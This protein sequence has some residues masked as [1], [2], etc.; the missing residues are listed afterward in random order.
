MLKGRGLQESST[1]NDKP[2]RFVQRHPP[3]RAPLSH[4]RDILKLQT[5]ARPHERPCCLEPVRTVCRCL[6]EQLLA[7]DIAACVTAVECDDWEYK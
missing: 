5:N 6:P 4:A 2:G 1:A 7:G 3:A